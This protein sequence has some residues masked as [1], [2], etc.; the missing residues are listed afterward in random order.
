MTNKVKLYRNPERNKPENMRIHTPFYQQEGIEPQ[1]YTSPTSPSYLSGTVRNAPMSTDNPRASRPIIRQG[2]GE[3]APSPIG[4]GRGSLPNVGNNVEQTWASV[5]GEIVDDIS[6]AD[7][8]EEMI[9]NNDFVS[10]EALGL[11]PRIMS[12]N[13]E[14]EVMEESHAEDDLQGAA[15]DE[16]ISLVLQQLEEEEYLLLVS[17]ECIASGPMEE[18]Q[19]QARAMVFGEH[20]LCDGNPTP[21]D[22]IVVIKRVSVKVGLFLS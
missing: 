14:F 16:Y 13:Q 4:R 21:I 10:S 7:P 19:E 15:K 2:Y 18:I 11:P 9:D 3:A 6:G 17:G 1:Q 22:D 8:N 20:S 12:E 5:D